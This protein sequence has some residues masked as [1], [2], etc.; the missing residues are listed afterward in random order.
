MLSCI[1]RSLFSPRASV[2]NPLIM[3]RSPIGSVVRVTRPVRY[4][5]YRAG[6]N[7]WYLGARDWNTTSQQFNGIQPVS[8]PFLSAAQHGLAFRYLDTAGAVL[9]TP[10][11]NASSITAIRIDLRA[12]TSAPVRVLSAAGPVAAR[13]D[14]AHV[15][16]LLHNRK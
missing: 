16:V 3:P 2:A 5:L 8:G 12:Q 15:I 4:S 14:S 13:V 1:I 10:I 7:L 11:A 6:D 9:A